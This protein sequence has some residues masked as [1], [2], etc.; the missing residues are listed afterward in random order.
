MKKYPLKRLNMLPTLL[1]PTVPT[2]TMTPPYR[3]LPSEPR[4]PA[5]RF[6]DLR[7]QSGL[8][9]EQVAQ[10]AGLLLRIE[11]LAEIGGPVAAAEAEQIRS[12]FCRLTGKF[13]T[14]DELHIVIQRK[15]Q[16][17]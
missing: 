12:A 7:Q 8:S 13:Y 6:L 1:L 17:L 2:T 9:G 11:Y 5:V 3:P 4:R 15:E 14:V 16:L 10:A